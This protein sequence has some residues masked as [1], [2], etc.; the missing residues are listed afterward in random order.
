[1][2][3]QPRADVG[4]HVPFSGTL[5]DLRDSRGVVGIAMRTATAANQ[6]VQRVI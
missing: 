6:R 4:N 5:I 2:S 1:M 3:F